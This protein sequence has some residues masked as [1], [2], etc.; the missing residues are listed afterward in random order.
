MKRGWLDQELTFS[1]AAA[2]LQRQDDP[3]G[4]KLRNLVMSR[5]RETGKRIALR[6]SNGPEPKLRITIG[7]IYRHLPELRPAR[8]D[9]LARLV[10]PMLDRQEARTRTLVR[11]EI[12]ETVT[13]RMERM[14]KKAASIEKCLRELKAL[15]EQELSRTGDN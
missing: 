9:D 13:P 14:E 8:V 1:R 3:I 10:K 15:E 11:E 2:E 6:M 4:R 12:A 7:Q 5:E